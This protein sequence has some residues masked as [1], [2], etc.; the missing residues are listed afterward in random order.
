MSMDAEAFK[1][2]K[3]CSDELGPMICEYLAVNTLSVPHGLSVMAAA[4]ITV[5]ENLSRVIG[6]DPKVM[7]NTYI[8]GLKIGWEKQEEARKHKR[9]IKK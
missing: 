4:T 6:E 9:I 7:F 2:I 1:H 3:E 8:D 5:I